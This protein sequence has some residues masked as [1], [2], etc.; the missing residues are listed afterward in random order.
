MAK[1]DIIKAIDQICEEKG[2][3]KQSVLETIAAALA[4]AYRKDFGDKTQNIQVEFN[5]ETGGSRIFDVKEVVSDE[6]HDVW[7]KER[8]EL[9]ARKEAEEKALAEGKPLP[10]PEM[11]A[12][13]VEMAKGEDTEE[14]PRYDPR[15]NVSVTQGQELQKGAKIGDVIRT[16]LFPPAE[17]GRM[18]AQTAKQVIIQK[19]REAERETLFNNFKGR[20]GEIFTA[21]VQRMEGRNVL[22]DIGRATAI[23]PPQE[24]IMRERYHP[25]DRCKVILRSVQSTPKGPEIIVSRSHEDM[26]AHLFSLEVPEIASGVIEIK[27]VAREAGAR[28]KIAVTTN[29]TNIDPVGSCVGQRG[30]RVQTVIAEL[31]GEK[32]D[33]LG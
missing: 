13:P 29:D 7:E 2:I 25:G 1:S 16:E 22:L 20:E 12:E 17:Y 9:L 5:P 19:L 14:E 4:V 32:D 31:G 23:M 8:A 6:L 30:S 33:I 11:K 24:Q 15:K 10:E 27:A 18:A 28:S 26:V 3:A 21:A